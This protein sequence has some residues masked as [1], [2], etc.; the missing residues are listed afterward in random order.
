MIEALTASV[1]GAAAYEA[2]RDGFP[3]VAGTEFGLRSLAVAGTLLVAYL[4]ISMARDTRRRSNGVVPCSTQSAALRRAT[5]VTLRSLTLWFGL[6]CLGLI[7]VTVIMGNPVVTL[8]TGILHVVVLSAL[9]TSFSMLYLAR[10]EQ[11]LFRLARPD[12]GR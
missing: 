3:L 1:V 12:R 11:N 7:P 8:L 5:R 4:A 10:L 2:L 6:V 9:V